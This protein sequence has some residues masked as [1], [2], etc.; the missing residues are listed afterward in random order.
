MISLALPFSG[1]PAWAETLFYVA[2]VSIVLIWLWT[3]VLFLLSRRAL[4]SA[5]DPNDDAAD[6]FLWVFLVPALNEE[7]TIADSVSRLLV[8]E[9]RNKAILVI[10]DGS[11][12]GTATVLD[13]FDTPDLE[14]LRRLAPDARQGKHAALNAAWRDLDQMLTSTRLSV[15]P[16][17][18]VIVCIVDADGRLDPRS[19]RFAASHFTD[20][21]VGGLQVL[22]RIYNRSRALTWCQ[23]VEFSIFG[24]LYQA[25]RT[26]YGA[27][28]MGGNGQFNRLSALDEIADE[29]VGGPWRARLTEDQDLG[30]RLIEAGW[31]SVADARTSVDQQGLPGF[32]KLLRQRTRWAQGNL[33][34]MNH[35]GKMARAPRPILVRVDQIAY[36][37]QP[38]FQ[39]LVGV[40]FVA[41]IFLAIF[42]VADYWAGGRWWVLLFF[43][44]LGYGGILLGCL[45]RGARTGARG[46]LLGVLIVPVYAAYSWLL[47]PVLAR[48]VIRQVTGRRA[49]TKTAREQ[50]GDA[51]P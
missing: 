29:N 5:P 20:D 40:A 4:G 12:D 37:L 44:L 51:T 15:W 26:P 11:T 50:V 48:A 46:I 32:R 3:F 17:D 49:W 34:A 2:F 45:A 8:V 14:V 7:V 30:L 9:A 38:A 39:A 24:L 47:W 25:G 10:D 41:S 43:F 21:R 13:T 42:D 36:L 35:V 33:Q 22:V 6:N 1:L 19:P 23:D 28:A 31:R 18:R 16:R 27:A